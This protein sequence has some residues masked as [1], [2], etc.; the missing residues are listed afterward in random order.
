MNMVCRTMG[1][2]VLAGVAA[3]SGYGQ[4]TTKTKSTDPASSDNQ[5]WCHNLGFSVQTSVF[6]VVDDF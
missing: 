3:V 1:I 5:T 6:S 4:E 2:L